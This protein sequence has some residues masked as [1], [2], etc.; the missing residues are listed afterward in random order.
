M[1]L[2]KPALD[3]DTDAQHPRSGR[4][5]HAPHWPCC[6]FSGQATERGRR[7]SLLAPVLVKTLVNDFPH[8]CSSPETQIRKTGRAPVPTLSYLAE[9]VSREGRAATQHESRFSSTSPGDF[10][11]AKAQLIILGHRA[12][13]LTAE[14]ERL[15]APSDKA[16]NKAAQNATGLGSSWKSLAANKLAIRDHLDSGLAARCSR[17]HGAYLIVASFI[18]YVESLRDTSSPT[19]RQLGAKLDPALFTVLDRLRSLYALECILADLGDLTEDGYLGPAQVRAVREASAMLMAEIRPDAVGLVEAF[20]M[21][22]WYL[23]SPLGAS[24]ELLFPN[25]YEDPALT[26]S[27]SRCSASLASTHQTDAPTSA[28]SN[29]C[30]ASR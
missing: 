22:D 23:A 15:R 11:D 28:S 5:Q 26:S 2:P 12:A 1:T 6:E 3:H 30:N 7:L 8:F 20:D 25:I 19:V 29:G 13:R 10:L 9:Y 27:L 4:Q 16:S 14:L 21:D 18:E 17:A 24:G